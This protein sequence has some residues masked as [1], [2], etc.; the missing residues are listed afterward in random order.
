MKK[1]ATGAI[2]FVLSALSGCTH[3]SSV[4]MNASGDRVAIG[5]NHTYLGVIQTNDAV[6]CKLSDKGLWDCTER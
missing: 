2:V 1:L 3:I 5:Y 4:A 6:V